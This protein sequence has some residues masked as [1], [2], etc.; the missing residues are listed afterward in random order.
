M[1]FN[2]LKTDLAAENDPD[3]FQMPYRLYG[4][5]DLEVMAH[6]YDRLRKSSYGYIV[7]LG[8]ADNRGERW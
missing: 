1:N 2:A 7:R 8:I 6:K 5:T 3:D 4:K